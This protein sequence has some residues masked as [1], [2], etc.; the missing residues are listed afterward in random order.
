MLLWLGRLGVSAMLRTC[1]RII[2]LT[3]MV[4]C[5]SMTAHAADQTLT[6]SGP[7]KYDPDPVSMGLVVNLTTLTVQGASRWGPYLFDDQLQITDFE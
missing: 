3:A 1:S 7:L 6:L 5:S 2:A 4:T